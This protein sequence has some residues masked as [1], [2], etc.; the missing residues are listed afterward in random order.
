MVQLRI[1]LMDHAPT[2]W[3][4]LIVPG[5]I[6]LSKLHCIFQAAMGW[7]DDHLHYFEID[8]ERNDVPDEG[9]EIR[10][11]DEKGVTVEAIEPVALILKFRHL[12]RRSAC[13][14]ARGLRRDRWL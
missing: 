9:W 1:S 12:S 5:E 11:T 14:P 7:D 3:R 6:K 2:I 8:D 4:R 10:D 13:L